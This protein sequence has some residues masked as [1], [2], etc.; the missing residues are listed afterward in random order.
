MSG[1]AQVEMSGFR[2][3]LSPGSRM[4]GHGAGRNEQERIGASRG[5]AARCRGTALAGEGRGVSESSNPQ[6]LSEVTT[7]LERFEA[8]QK[9]KRKVHNDRAALRRKALI[10]DAPKRR[11]G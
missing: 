4:D 6:G 8:E 1:S 5:R 10:Q 11:S 3:A 2:G 9:A 7:V